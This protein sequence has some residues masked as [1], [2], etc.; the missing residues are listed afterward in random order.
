MLCRSCWTDLTCSM[1]ICSLLRISGQAFF[2]TL[3]NI[4]LWALPSS[5]TW[6]SV[7]AAALYNTLRPKCHGGTWSSSRQ[8]LFQQNPAMS[9]GNC[10][11][12]LQPT[13][14]VP[15]LQGRLFAIN[16]TEGSFLFSRLLSKDLYPFRTAQDHDFGRVV[17]DVNFFSACTP[18]LYI[19]EY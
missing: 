10:H 13:N 6:A 19:C 3:Q 1:P 7:N 2:S 18:S 11:L 14:V 12:S 5:S 15:H 9:S 17:A 16:L 4:Q 8:D